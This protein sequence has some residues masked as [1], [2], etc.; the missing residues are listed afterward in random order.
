ME[1]HYWIQWS[2]S[3]YSW[4]AY[5]RFMEIIRLGLKFD[6]QNIKTVES[7]TH[8]GTWQSHLPQAY[9]DDKYSTGYLRNSN[10]DSDSLGVTDS[11]NESHRRSWYIPRILAAFAIIRLEVRHTADLEHREP[12]NQTQPRYCWLPASH[13][14]GPLSGLW[15][16]F[17][18]TSD[19]AIQSSMV[20]CD[21]YE[22]K[23]VKL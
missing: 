14:C 9:W 15:L 20:F 1:L 10:S 11:R 18:Y 13:C 19:S 3:N 22:A 4:I 23:F 7:I 5:L 6:I 12:D 2:D 21:F 17:R 8:T 16:K